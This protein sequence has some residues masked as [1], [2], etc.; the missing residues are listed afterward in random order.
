MK[1]LLVNPPWYSEEGD[2]SPTFSLG[3]AYIAAV[4]REN[5]HKVMLIDADAEGISWKEFKKRLKNFSPDVLGI[6][7]TTSTYFSGIRA[8]QLG[9]EIGCFTVMGGPH[10]SAI[11]HESLAKSKYLDAVC[12][13]EGE[14]TM[15]ELVEKLE[16]GKPLDDV[17]GL[18]FRKG[19][20]IIH[21]LP[22]E[23]IRNLDELPFPARDL[24][25]MKQKYRTLW[26]HP[27]GH[28]FSSRGCPNTCTFCASHLVFGKAVRFRSP[29][30]VLDEIE[31]M[32]NRFGIKQFA[33]SDDTFTTWPRRVEQ[34]CDGIIERGLD[35]KW[36]CQARANTVNYG[37]LKKMKD[38][39]C[40]QIDYGVE[41]GDPEVLKKMKKNINHEQVKRAIRLT[42]LLGMKTFAYYIIGTPYDDLETT[43]KTINFAK[44]LGASRSYFNILVP[45]P[46]TEIYNEA[47]ANGTLLIEDWSEFHQEKSII[48]T[49]LPRWYI[50]K[51]YRRAKMELF[52]TEFFREVRH[53]RFRE[54]WN[55]TKRG[56]NFLKRK[57]KIV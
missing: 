49:K 3:I 44:K 57:I 38:A 21:N 36:V 7:S 32:V 54:V 29:E 2:I 13:G 12:R 45:Y 11:P 28:I 25:P 17:K 42:N 33:F 50:E 39:G 53:L 1:I 8:A 22:R 4:L 37:L 16:N 41:S 40:I 55:D 10:V 6:T 27:A 48:K 51:V 34:I 15:L 56:V 14:Y 23:P 47:K 31:E 30:N 20:K 5:G 52:L 24:L 43:R 18:S 46:G 19:R 9:K 26:G 35:V